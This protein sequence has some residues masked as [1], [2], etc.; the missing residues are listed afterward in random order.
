[1]LRDGPKNTAV[2]TCRKAFGDGNQR[3]SRASKNVC[4]SEFFVRE[5]V[6]EGFERLMISNSKVLRLN[7][8]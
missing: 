7:K 4:V 5:F 1:V 6:V 8:L 2:I 3:V